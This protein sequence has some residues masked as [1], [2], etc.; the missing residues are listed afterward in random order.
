MRILAS[1]TLLTAM[2]A[3]SS[4]G[5][6]AAEGA[7]GP[8]AP[9]AE[10]VPIHRADGTVAWVG[11]CATPEP[12]ARATQS[13][14]G[15]VFEVPTP[16]DCDSDSTNPTGDYDPGQ[17]YLVE[18]WVHVIEN[19]AGTEGDVPDSQVHAQIAILNEDFRSI[20]GTLG[21]NGNDA[22]LYFKLAGITRSNNDTWYNDGGA[23]YDTLAVDP[24]NYLNIYTNSASGNLGYVPQLPTDLPPGGGFVGSNA[25]RV[26]I[27]WESFGRDSPFVPY[28]L[29]RTTTHEVG[30][31]F[32]LEHPFCCG[33]GTATPPACNTSGDLICDTNPDATSH[34]GCPA[35][36][37]S[38]GSFPV[39]ID[40][41]MEY[42]DDDCM[43]EFTV[44]QRRRMRCALLHYRPLLGTPILF[45]D[46][47]EYGPNGE[48][49]LRAWSSVTP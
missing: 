17:A 32:G 21:E 49:G 38:C 3:V 41:Y 39:P 46:G 6:L 13:Y 11:R 10:L 45:Y 14:V 44:E 7:P 25:D 16:A 19:L 24:H 33:C 26:V 48:D 2:L 22:A 23:Y 15:P 18:V 34:F 20:L 9:G 47:F 28:H 8:Q 35:G 30:H 5:S 4:A 37:T 29:G 42:T 27:L 40:N 12:W 31:Y 43:E 36:A 1:W